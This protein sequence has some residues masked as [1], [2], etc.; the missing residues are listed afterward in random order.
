MAHERFRH[1]LID[2]RGHQRALAESNRGEASREVYVAAWVVGK[3]QSQLAGALAKN[4]AR[5]H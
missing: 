1:G 5:C 3:E 4:G 2:D